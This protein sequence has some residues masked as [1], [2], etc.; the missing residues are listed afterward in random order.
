MVQYRQEIGDSFMLIILTLTLVVVSIL[1]LCVKKS[2]ESIYMFG[3]CLSLM[4]EIC[5]VMIFIAKKGGVSQ[6]VMQFLYISQSVRTRIQ[7]FLIT[8]NQLGFLIALGR[9]L[10]P[11]FFAGAGDVLFYDSFYSY[12]Y[13]DTKGSG[14]FASN[15]A[16]SLPAWN[17]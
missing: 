15:H 13:L 6:E 11:F 2:R 4:L 12:Q 1:T 5:G 3:L 14:I 9:T 7:Y 16:D 8:L 17:L 10:F